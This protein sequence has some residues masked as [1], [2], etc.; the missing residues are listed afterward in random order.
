MAALGSITAVRPTLTTT[1]QRVAYGATIAAGQT[2]Y[3]DPA[4]SLYKLG[5][6]NASATTATVYGI[7]MTPGVNG[8]YG[9]VATG[10][11]IILVGTTMA[12]GTQYFAGGTAGEIIPAGDFAT[13]DYVT[14]IGVGAS[15]TQMDLNIKVTGILHA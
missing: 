12:I 14:N 15:A 13:N 2:V 3:Q 7:A 5:D 11:S 4:D 1:Y 8:G 6:N 9:L 10:G